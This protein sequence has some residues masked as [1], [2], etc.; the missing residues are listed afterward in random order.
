ML[1][2]AAAENS[3]CEGT[4]LYLRPQGRSFTNEVVTVYAVKGAYDAQTEETDAWVSQTEAQADEVGTVRRVCTV[5]TLGEALQET[6]DAGSQEGGTPGPY[7]EGEKHAH[8][9][10]CPHDAPGRTA[11]D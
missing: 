1:P 6:L 9:W 8:S 4:F 5:H 2:L 7:T 3:L 11:Q 10:Q